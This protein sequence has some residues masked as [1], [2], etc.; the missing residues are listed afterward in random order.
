MSNKR[1]NISNEWLRKKI[2]REP[3]GEIGAGFNLAFDK[4]KPYDGIKHDQ[5]FFDE[6]Q[7]FP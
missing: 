4:Y 6:S 7:Y 3:E 2:E 1:P 5:M